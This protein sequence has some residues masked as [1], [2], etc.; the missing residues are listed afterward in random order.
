MGAGVGMRKITLLS[1]Y[2]YLFLRMRVGG[3]C[4]CG[5]GAP[6]GFP[7]EKAISFQTPV[8]VIPYHLKGK[9]ILYE[10]NCICNLHTS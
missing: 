7:R 5:G 3:A 4:G 10:K 1:T 9:N 8:I 2:F 6:C